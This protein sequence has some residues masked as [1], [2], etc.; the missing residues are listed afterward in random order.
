MNIGVLDHYCEGALY[1]VGGTHKIS[2]SLVHTIR[3]FGGT[4]LTKA[5]VTKIL[6]EDGRAVGVEVCNQ[7]IKCNNIISDAG[8]RMTL[9][10]LPEAYRW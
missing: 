5:A 9:S 6:V 7:T 4:V 8:I 10:L 3:H 2:E 1:P